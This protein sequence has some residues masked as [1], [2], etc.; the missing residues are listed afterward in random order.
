MKDR[1]K[2][3]NQLWSANNFKGLK[4]LGWGGA[5][6]VFGDLSPLTTDLAAYDSFYALDL[7]L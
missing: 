4:Q 3:T 2:E 7:P 1:R 5:K 6:I